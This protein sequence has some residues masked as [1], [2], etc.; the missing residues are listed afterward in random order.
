MSAHEQPQVP[1]IARPTDT[2]V[3]DAASMNMQKV[4]TV[5]LALGLSVSWAVYLGFKKTVTYSEVYSPPRSEGDHKYEQKVDGTL[6]YLKV[7]D[8]RERDEVRSGLLAEHW[9][10][11]APYSL[12]ISSL[13][14]DGANG[15][16]VVTGV[17]M[18]IG[19]QDEF[20]V[21]LQYPLELI[22]ERTDP[23]VAFSFTSFRTGLGE[24][25]T[26]SPEQVVIVRM[27]YVQPGR[28]EPLSIRTRFEPRASTYSIT[29]L[30]TLLLGG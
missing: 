14:Y 4:F 18:T 9:K 1:S 28:D 19:A 10:R 20:L 16:L 5:L 29:A 13:N 26:F 21:D 7:H 25:L 3:R 6:V 30:E 24:R 17:W 11:G 8:S 22:Y 12:L 15:P 2:S 27:D 23:N